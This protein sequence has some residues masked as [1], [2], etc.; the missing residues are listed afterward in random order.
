MCGEAQS[1]T[2]MPTIHAYIIQL[3]WSSFQ[4][5]NSCPMGDDLTVDQKHWLLEL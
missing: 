1:L 2:M 3:I 4:L 5:S